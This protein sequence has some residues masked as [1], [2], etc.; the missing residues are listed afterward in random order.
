MADL[1]IFM[2]EWLQEEDCDM[3]LGPELVVNGTFDTNLTGWSISGSSAWSAGTANIL[4]GQ[5]DQQLPLIEA[6]GFFEFE[7]VENTSG[8]SLVGYSDVV[9][10]TN[11]EVG[12]HSFTAPIAVEEA[13]RVLRFQVIGGN[14][15]IDNVSV[16]EVL[17]GGISMEIFEE[18]WAD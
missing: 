14:M 13:T 2:S 11:P 1:I 8:N 17:G 3:S 15:K 7:I 12:V 16:R 10:F 4:G 9:K 5:L 6:D 18:M